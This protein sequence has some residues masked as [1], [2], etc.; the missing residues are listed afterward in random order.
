MTSPTWQSETPPPKVRPTAFGLLRATLRG[1]G[2]VITLILGLLVLLT[3]R[4]VERGFSGQRRFASNRVTQITCQICLA[5]IGLRRKTSGDA[6]QNGGVVVANH[7][8]WLDILVLN[9]GQRV[10]FVSKAEV[11]GWPGIGA[12][13]KA[14]GTLFIARDRR[15]AQAH[16]QQVNARIGSGAQLLFFPEGTSSDGTRVL[17]FKSTLFAGMMDTDITLQAVTVAYH[18]PGGQD[19]RFYGWWGDMDLGPHL[20]TVLSA[21]QGGVQVTYHPSTQARDHADRKALTQHLQDQ[22]TRGLPL[23]RIA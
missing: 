20:L 11:A 17:P 8:S 6:M 9:A 19:A 15:Q 10:S 21:R 22:V 12:L 4:A 7:S 2:C 23:H 5:I 14:T 16:V 18:A 13:A 1:A 3:V